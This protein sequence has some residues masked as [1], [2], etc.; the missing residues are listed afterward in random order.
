MASYELALS[1]KLLAACRVAYTWK[2]FCYQGSFSNN[3]RYAC[4]SSYHKTT[5]IKCIWW[6]CQNASLIPFT[7]NQ[8]NTCATRM[9]AV[10]DRYHQY[11]LKNQTR[12]K[13]PGETVAW[14]TQISEKVPIP[15][16]KDWQAFLKINEN[17]NELFKF[18]SDE[19]V[20]ATSTSDYC[21]STT[22]GKLV[23]SNKAVDLSDITPS[24]HEEADSRMMLH[25]HHAV[26]D[27]HQKAFLHTVDSDIIV[28]SVHLFATFQSLSLLNCGSVSEV[29]KRP[30]ISQLMKFCYSLD[31]ITA[32]HYHSYMPLQVV[33]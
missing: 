9:D 3:P 21:L 22:T 25:L 19:L 2:K 7:E 16:G 24:D 29:E 15:K 8:T 5:T 23:L 33:T 32:M 4:C 20:N 17:K 10:W 26:M 1:L 27:G 30:Q 28:L 12:A 31:S 18:L 13:R 11:S 14:R 6:I